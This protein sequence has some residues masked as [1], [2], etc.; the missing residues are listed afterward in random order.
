MASENAFMKHVR[1][2]GWIDEWEIAFAAKV[3]CTQG[4]KRIW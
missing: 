2:Q 4:R 1:E 3:Q